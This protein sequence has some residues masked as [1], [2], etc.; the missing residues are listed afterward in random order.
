[1]MHFSCWPRAQKIKKDLK[2]EALMDCVLNALGLW[3][4]PI[5]KDGFYLYRAVSEKVNLST[6]MILV[7]CVKLYVFID[8][9]NVFVFIY[10][11]YLF[12]NNK[13]PTSDIIFCV[14]NVFR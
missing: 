2:D 10:L 8:L 11:F 7:A 13:V 12:V 5:A 3:R 14:W 9:M 6:R 4:K 1:M